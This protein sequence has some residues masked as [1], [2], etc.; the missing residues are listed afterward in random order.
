M[1]ACTTELLV[2]FTRVIGGIFETTGMTGVVL[3]MG[4]MCL[5][6]CLV[7]L[8]TFLVGKGLSFLGVMGI[9]LDKDIDKFNWRCVGLTVGVSTFPVIFFLVVSNGGLVGEGLG[10][11]PFGIVGLEGFTSA[12]L[13]ANG[14]EWVGFDM[15]VGFMLAGFDTLF[16]F[17]LDGF[18]TLV[19]LVLLSFDALVGLELKAFD[20]RVC[21]ELLG[22][23]TLMG[24]ETAG[25][26]LVN[27]CNGFTVTV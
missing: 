22:F 15:V 2:G 10:R 21:F 23:D 12:G 14:F 13:E 5:G 26:G 4:G 17:E 1:V 27:M 18:D 3:G 8:A 11:G 6:V 20:M 19:G 16:G 24:F 7:L 25:F 9:L